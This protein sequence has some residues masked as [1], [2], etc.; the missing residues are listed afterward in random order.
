MRREIVAVDGMQYERSEVGL[1]RQLRRCAGV[2]RVDV[3]ARAGIADITYDESH[4]TPRRLRELIAQS[5]YATPNG[6]LTAMSM[7]D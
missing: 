2:V 1:G 7:P 3:D 4:I 5:G 6:S